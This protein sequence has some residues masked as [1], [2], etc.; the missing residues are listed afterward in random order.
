MKSCFFIG[1]REAPGKL[2]P[3]LSEAIERH[4]TEYGVKEF[5][6]G[7]I[8]RFRQNGGTKAD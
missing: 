7:G 8:W 3:F 5:I 2:Y 1:H 6:V 4:I